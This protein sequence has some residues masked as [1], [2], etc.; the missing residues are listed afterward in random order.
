MQAN[1]KV[2]TAL[3][4]PADFLPLSI[5]VSYCLIH[6]VDLLVL[7]PEQLLQDSSLT[8]IPPPPSKYLLFQQL[9]L[10]TGPQ[11][12]QKSVKSH[13]GFICAK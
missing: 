3:H 9:L 4:L 5:S 12:T 11:N 2:I 6:Q 1:E 7:T 13:K 10:L 8:L